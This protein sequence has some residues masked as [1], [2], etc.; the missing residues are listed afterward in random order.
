MKVLRNIFRWVFIFCLPVLLLTASLAWGFNSKWIFNYGFKKY[1]VSTTTGLSAENL[2]KIAIS[3][4]SYIN[5]GREYWDIVITQDKES[6]TL[7]TREEQLHFKDVKALVW[8]DYSVFF[9]TL[10]LC[11]SNIVYLL[12]QKSMKSYRRLARDAVIGSLL[13][14]GLMLLLG[15]ASFL[16][17][18]ALFLKM[19]S[20]IFTNDYWYAEGYMLI[21]FPG[22]FWY[23]AVFICIGL[24]AVLTIIIGG[25]GFL[26]LKLTGRIKSQDELSR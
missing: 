17:F 19:H 25:S 4:T 13:S 11:L 3:W 6:F 1:S 26:I 10:L 12:W 15:A 16:D 24:M 5:S 21:L 22:E 8:L 14:V 23:D 9:V 18:D 7:F 20:L 2:N